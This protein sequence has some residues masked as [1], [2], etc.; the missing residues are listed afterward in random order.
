[1]EQTTLTVK[2]NNVPRD[3]LD[4]C[5]LTLAERANF[6]YLDWPAL[7]RGEESA[8]FFRFKGR[9]YDLGGFMVST[10]PQLAG[11]DGYESDT[12]FSVTLVRFVENGERVVVG[13]VYS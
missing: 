5:E 12:F 11:W 9:V 4:A 6:D 13:R 10:D 1:M 2:T 3:V 8:S 7:E